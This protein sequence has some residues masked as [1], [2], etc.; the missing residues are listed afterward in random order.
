MLIFFFRVASWLFHRERWEKQIF[1]IAL[2]VAIVILSFLGAFLIRVENINFLLKTDTYTGCSIALLS[3]M[4]VFC[5][6][7]LYSA[8][9]RHFSTDAAL[10]IVISSALA[11]IT[12]TLAIYMLGLQIPRSVPVIFAT[13]FSIFSIGLRFSIRA[14]NQEISKKQKKSVI[15]YG[16]GAAG[17]QL[18]SALKWNPTFRV[19]QFIDDNKKLH[20]QTIAGVPINSFENA[21][22]LLKTKKVDTLL[23]TFPIKSIQVKE[24]ILNLLSE[25]RLQ[26]KTIPSLSDLISESSEV[27]NFQ[28]IAIEDLLGRGTVDPDP[29]LMAKNIAGKTVLVTGAGGSIGRELCKQIVKWHPQKLIL[30]DLSEYSIYA[31][32]Q[33]L[34][35]E[36]QLTIENVTP[37]IGSVQDP[38]LLDEIFERFKIDTIYHAAAYKHVPLMEQ[39]I[40]QC[41]MNNVFGT[42]EIA[43]K[44][45]R[46]HVKKFVLVS[47]DK[48]VNPTNIMGASKRIA[49]LI[50]KALMRKQKVV[51]FSVVRFG[52]VL[53][54]SGSVVPLF[55]Q[56]ISRGGPVTVTHED[57]TRYFMTIPEAA[58]LVIQAGS[59]GKNGDIFVLDMGQSIKII[60]LARKMIMLSGHRPT[61]DKIASKDGEILIA[62]TGLRPG[63]KL[64]E[65]LSYGDNL[66]KTNHP[67]IKTAVEESITITELENLLVL[68][69]EALAGND[70]STILK[71]VST[72]SPNISRLINYPDTSS[73]CSNK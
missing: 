5:L 64:Y 40:R 53:G 11:T 67:Y 16:A 1:L 2:D 52:N 36:A 55:K 44:A 43:E 58:Q 27:H 56:Q 54:S 35:I 46:A 31:L 21:V 47:T 17:T 8:S 13:L 68:L 24:K 22:K 37:L 7:R 28:D 26:V 72:V 59:M 10:T 38:R 45:V 25:Y 14:L 63:E 18:M 6:R 66:R 61:Q 69:K 20:G 3:S 23:L 30:L 32:I 42:L 39:N 9:T 15:I 71:I 34:E 65:E 49:E 50:C 29:N 12:L 70:L 73:S 57:V 41:L 60:D 48:A 19:H 33:D 62:T 51:N 4:A